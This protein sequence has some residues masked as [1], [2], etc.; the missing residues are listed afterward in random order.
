[1]KKILSLITLLLVSTA[2][3]AQNLT[4]SI[5]DLN[6]LWKQNLDFEGMDV[7][8]PEEYMLLDIDHDGT[9]E[10]FLS[11]NSG[12]KAVFLQ[13]NGKLEMLAYCFGEFENIT[14]FDDGYLCLIQESGEVAGNAIK[15]YY[16]L[17]DSKVLRAIEQDIKGARINNVLLDNEGEKQMLNPDQS[18]NF[19][20]KGKELQVL[21]TGKWIP[22][23]EQKV[24][25]L[26]NLDAETLYQRALILASK[27]EF[28][29]AVKYYTVAAEKGHADAQFELAHS[30]ERGL[31]I[32]LNTTKAQVWY[33]KAVKQ[34]LK[35]ADLKNPHGMTQLG[36]CYLNGTGVEKNE[37]AA[38]Q[39]YRQAVDN[40]YAPA[41]ERMGYCYIN[42]YGV[43]KNYQAA[44]QLYRQAAEQNY[45]PAFFYLGW[46]YEEGV[47]VQKNIKEA[48]EWYNKAAT[49][50]SVNAQ[51]KLEELQKGGKN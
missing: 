40:N 39:W 14:V 29:S 30:Y 41:L 7:G 45:V 9:E 35:E 5:E 27:E 26:E 8:V 13:D 25:D 11:A 17:K 28:S 47:G 38:V 46:C 49:L 16:Q 31:G 20:P 3:I 34:Y 22:L 50:G 42:G 51:Q 15:T 23:Q 36:T 19:L 1:M 24:S 10:L 48:V 2:T 43:P 21:E 12:F 37:K 44:V 33:A 18:R 4:H 6:K 32:G